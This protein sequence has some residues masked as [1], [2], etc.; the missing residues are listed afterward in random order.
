MAKMSVKKSKMPRFN[1]DVKNDPFYL[2]GFEIGY[3]EGLEISAT[4]SVEKLLFEDRFSI[5]FIAEIVGRPED[6]VLLI[7]NRLIQEGKL[8]PRFEAFSA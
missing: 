6:F 3:K 2:D 7:Q 1:I 8:L 4:K 5:Q